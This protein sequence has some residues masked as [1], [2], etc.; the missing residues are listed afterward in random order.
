[1]QNTEGCVSDTLT[2]TFIVTS[3]L[4]FGGKKTKNVKVVISA[5]WV[6]SVVMSSR[7]LLSSALFFL[8]L[9]YVE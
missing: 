2:L 4:R 8:N 9:C 7:G 3:S 6:K 5:M 1:M